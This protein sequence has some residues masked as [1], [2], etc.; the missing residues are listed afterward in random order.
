MSDKHDPDRRQ[1]PAGSAAATGQH[2]AAAD[3]SAAPESGQLPPGEA[4][5]AGDS[6]P[7]SAHPLP[8]EGKG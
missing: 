3:V 6:G 2:E 4:Q 1:K 5:A 7:T 8:R